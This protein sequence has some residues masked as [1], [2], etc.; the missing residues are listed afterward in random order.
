M[1]KEGSVVKIEHNLA[2]EKIST[3]KVDDDDDEMVGDVDQ[4][5]IKMET[6]SVKQAESSDEQ[7]DKEQPCVDTSHTLSSNENEDDYG[8][9]F[10]TVYYHS[11]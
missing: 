6:D 7:E 9:L 10:F 8:V 11:L 1:T 3:I 5:Q 4:A 2:M